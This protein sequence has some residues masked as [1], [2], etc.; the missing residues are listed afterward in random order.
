MSMLAA[1]LNMSAQEVWQIAWLQPS[2]V[3]IGGKNLKVGDEFEDN[4]RTRIR[5]SSDDQVMKVLEKESHRCLVICAKALP[6][7]KGG[8]LR[9]YIDV[10]QQ[11]STRSI[12]YRESADKGEAF[13][14]IGF[15]KNG[16]TETLIPHEGMFMNNFPEEIWLCYVN[17]Q[18]G[19]KRVETKDFRSLVRY[20][21][22]TDDMV[23]RMMDTDDEDSYLSLMS[24]FMNPE[25]R[26]IPLTKEEIQIY[27]TLKF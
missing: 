4:A 2:P 22:I 23:R 8:K 9:E 26:N 27:V 17:T 7:R 14:F 24:Q 3:H 25:F 6:G 18:T 11:L 19:E 13:H 16:K 1:W 12:A 5:W 21:I 20:L 10:S 15:D